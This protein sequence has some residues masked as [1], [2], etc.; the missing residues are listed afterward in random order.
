M[1]FILF[2]TVVL[3]LILSEA[4]SYSQPQPENL[5]SYQYDGYDDGY[6]NNYGYDDYE[7]TIQTPID[8]SEII[9][10]PPPRHTDLAKQIPTICSSS[11]DEKFKRI[12]D[13]A[14]YKQADWSN[15]IGISHN[16]TLEEAFEIAKENPEITFFFYM[17]NGGMSLETKDGNYRNFYHNDAVFF[18]GKPWWGSAPGLSDGYIKK[19]SEAMDTK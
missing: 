16:T 6:D 12:C 17:K 11:K 5:S 1:I 18:K 10:P 8:D 2:K 3:H 14:M 19:S 13:V 15:V 4:T 7:G 9:T